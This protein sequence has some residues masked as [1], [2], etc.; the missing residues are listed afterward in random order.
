[1]KARFL[2]LPFLISTLVLAITIQLQAGTTGK[3]K[4]VV[5]DAE[6]GAP[7]PGVNVQLIQ[8]WRGEE[9]VPFAGLGGATNLNGEFVILQVPPGK[10]SVEATM[11]GYAAKVQQ[12]LRVYVDRTTQVDFILKPQ[13]VDLGGEVIVEAQRDMVQLDVTSTE[14]Y[15]TAE[16][17]QETPFAN[18]VED[19]IGLQ[20][21]ISGNII[22]GEI[23]IREGDALEVGFLLD[24]M[25]MVDKKFN[26]PV[27]SVQSGTV[28]EM[29]IMRNGFNAEYGQS[30]SGV[31]NIITKNPSNQYHFYLDYQFTP[32]QKPHY[33]RDKYDQAYRTEWRLLGGQNAFEGDTLYIPDGKYMREYTWIGW[34]KH[35]ENLLTDN[36]PNNDLTAEEAFE[37]WKW[38]HRPLSYGDKHGHNVDMTFSGGLPLIPWEA[39]FMLGGKY[40][41]HPFSY[42]QSRDHFDERIGSFKVVNSISPDIKLTFNSM[43]SEVRTVT[44]GNSDSEWSEE[45]RI[46]YSGG[47][48]PNYYP[49]SKPL[50][51]RY[52]SIAGL[53]LTHTISPSLFYEINLNHFYLKWNLGRP[54]SAR[55]E[56]GRYFHGRLYLD[57]QSGWIPRELG[58]EDHGDP[59]FQMYGGALTWDDSWNRRTVFSGS[60][61]KQYR[62][63]EFKSGFEFTYNILRE[64]REHWHD[65]DPNQLYTHDYRVEPFEIGLY[66]QDKIEFQGMI[67]N[68][69]LRLDYFNTNSARPNPHIAFQEEYTNAEVY[70]EILAGTYP[71]IRAKPKYYLSPRIGIA[72]PLSDNSKIYFNYGHFVQTPKTEVLFHTSVD[73]VENRVQFMNNSDMTFT[74][75]IAYEMGCDIGLGDYFQLHLGAFYKD[76]SDY[77]SGMVYVTLPDLALLMEWYDQN[78]YKEIRGLEIELRKTMG[79]FITGWFNY[80]YI[81]KSEANLEVPAFGSSC[82]IIANDPSFGR[83][84]EMWGIPR[85]DMVFIQP[86]ARGVIT[87]SA[88]EG[89][90]PKIKQYAILGNTNLSVQAHYQGG[91]QR[92]HPSEIFRQKNPD[93]IFR[94]ID[95][96]WAN[97]RLSRMFKIHDLQL[98]L[99]LDVSNIL[100]SKFRNPPGG[101]SG[102]DYYNDLFYSG[103]KDEVGTDELSDPMILRTESDDVY[104]AKLKTYVLGLRLNL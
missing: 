10:Y 51:N 56:D 54:D 97:M 41:Y 11:M 80:N 30:R 8:V 90:G 3:I 88:P 98:T 86:N 65:E 52:T 55:A 76:Y 28:Q 81:R 27:M 100:H 48:F 18:R 45:D 13:A 47:G 42:P 1:M 82:T 15:I 9:A 91:A 23:K 25:S 24:G 43:Y 62:A 67:A 22:E 7:L 95:R 92:E 69:G 85:S 99:Y 77:E 29:K 26:R 60:L 71:T 103:R 66:A 75:T 101:Q 40:E 57:P 72:H 32:A 20:S 4:G 44:Q 58:A 102:E 35:A 50:I 96:Y 6:N 21:G 19:V 34:N 93:V 63:H 104:W 16:E 84:G 14:N 2:F 94:E 49:F 64:K 70:Q 31:I 36:D 89:W 68:I 33:G 79:R 78:D 46:S 83:G 59:K 37:L 12:H 17:Y 39:N 38:R 74:K 73:H 5:H 61:I 87:F 53:K